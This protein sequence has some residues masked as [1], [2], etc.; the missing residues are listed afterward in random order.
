MLTERQRL[1]TKQIVH[2]AITH[3]WKSKWVGGL[4]AMRHKEKTLALKQKALHEN[5]A[6]DSKNK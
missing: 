6:L 5:N 1:H 2:S 3:P 4:S